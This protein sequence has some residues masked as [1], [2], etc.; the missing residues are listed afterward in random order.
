MKRY[1][2]ENL[3]WMIYSLILLCTNIILFKPD[4]GFLMKASMFILFA[5]TIYFAVKHVREEYNKNVQ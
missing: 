5:F 4:S 2:G 3:W 1:G